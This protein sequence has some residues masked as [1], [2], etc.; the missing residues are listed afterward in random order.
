MEEQEAHHQEQK[1]ESKAS[2]GFTPWLVVI[3]LLIGGVFAT[4]ANERQDQ[5]ARAAVVSYSSCE[6]QKK[7]KHS[8]YQVATKTFVTIYNLDTSCGNF[9]SDADVFGFVGVGEKYNLSVYQ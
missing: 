8:D 7:D 9:E 2:L 6:I 5:D 4:V 1:P 3:L